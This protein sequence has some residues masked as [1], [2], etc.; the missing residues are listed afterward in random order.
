MMSTV[1]HGRRRRP[2]AWDVP[3]RPL[4]SSVAIWTSGGAALAHAAVAPEH[5]EEWPAAG[6]FFVVLAVLQASFALAVARSRTTVPVL[7]TAVVGNVAVITLYVV[8][9][10]AGLPFGPEHVAHAHHHPGAA[11]VA[12]AVEGVGA[13]DLATLIAELAVVVAAVAMLPKRAVGRTTNALMVTGVALWVL[14][15]TGVLG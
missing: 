2:G 15:G 4:V 8:S 7:S 5:F 6:A 3:D 14:A 9:R 12:S 10:T 13:L 1:D 11:V